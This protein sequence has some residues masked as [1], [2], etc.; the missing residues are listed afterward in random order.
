MTFAKSVTP[1]GV[2]RS[3]RRGRLLVRAEQRHLILD[4]FD[5][6]PL[7][8]MAFARQ[9]GLCYSTFANWVQK[10]RKDAAAPPAPVACAATADRPV[11]AE[12]LV[13]KA[14]AA[15]DPLPCLKVNLSCGV[16]FEIT[17]HA[18]MPLV[19]GLV[20]ALSASRPC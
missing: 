14:K 13:R 16:S 17:D 8:A 7:S 15:P 18:Q 12:V 1:A 3:D 4:A 10:R 6:S 5:A 9:H 20:Q 19:I 2:I 11:F